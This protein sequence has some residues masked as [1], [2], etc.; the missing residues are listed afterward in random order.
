[1]KESADESD[2]LCLSR[3]GDVNQYKTLQRMVYKRT[4]DDFATIQ[5]ANNLVSRSAI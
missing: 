1:M 5:N 3:P 2:L 4:K